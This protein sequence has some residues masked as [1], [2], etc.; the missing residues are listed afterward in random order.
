MKAFFSFSFSV[1]MK[2]RGGVVGRFFFSGRDCM[3][4]AA[5]AVGGGGGGEATKNDFH[6]WK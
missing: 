1:T 6:L 3:G 2:R 4:W 5:P